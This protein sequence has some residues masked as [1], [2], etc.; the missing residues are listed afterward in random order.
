MMRPA[1][2][3]SVL[4]KTKLLACQSTHL[5]LHFSLPSYLSEDISNKKQCKFYEETRNHIFSLLLN[6]IGICC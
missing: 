5:G 1:R 2:D 4:D 3:H 6:K